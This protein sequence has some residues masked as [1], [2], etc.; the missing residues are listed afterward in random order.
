MALRPVYGACRMSAK[1]SPITA[2]DNSVNGRRT[3]LIA[4][5]NAVVPAGQFTSGAGWTPTLRIRNDN[6]RAGS[7]IVGAGVGA[8][9]G[10]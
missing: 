3:D 8:D 1:E 9:K 6:P 2:E 10:Y 5:H 4:V 7:G